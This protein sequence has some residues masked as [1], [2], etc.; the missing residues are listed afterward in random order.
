[1][2]ELMETLKSHTPN[3]ENEVFKYLATHPD[4]ELRIDNLEKAY[5]NKANTLNAD[6]LIFKN[7]FLNLKNER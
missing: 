6:S 3:I 4:L 2:I 7:I 1:M 5:P